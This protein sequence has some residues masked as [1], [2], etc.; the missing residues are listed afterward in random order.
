MTDYLRIATVTLRNADGEYGSDKTALVGIGFAIV[1]AVEELGNIV[2]ELRKLDEDIQ[3][4]EKS[5]V[6]IAEQQALR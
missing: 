3:A 2:E 5:Y 1:A 4:L 6:H